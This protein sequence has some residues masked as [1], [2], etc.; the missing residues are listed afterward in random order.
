MSAA[1]TVH[2]P[3]LG[4]SFGTAL[5]L[6]VGWFSILIGV[7]DL[8]LELD[9]TAG[10]PD[11]T[12]LIFHGVLLVGGALL[13]SLSSI[14]ARPGFPGYLAGVLVLVTG[15][16]LTAVPANDTVCCLTSFAER[17]GYPFTIMARATGG[18]W[19]L[20]GPHF[21]IDLLFWAYAGLMVLVLV[22]LARRVTSHRHPRG[23]PRDGTGPARP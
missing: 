3:G 1:G 9:R 17:H 19:H 20:D 6:L 4:E 18:G 13:V 5:R 7:L 15:V 12:Y 2:Q 8:G 14:A 11:S 10:A 22:G 16:V 23:A 21:L